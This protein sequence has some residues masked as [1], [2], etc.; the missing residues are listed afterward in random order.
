VRQA[1]IYAI[2]RALGASTAVS[3]RRRR[4]SSRRRIPQYKKANL[5]PYNVAKAKALIKSDA[6]R[7]VLRLLSARATTR[8]RHAPEAGQYSG[9]LKS[10]A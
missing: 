2:T 8:L 3:R 4:T 6:A 9:V 5:Y 1:V 10:I 7:R